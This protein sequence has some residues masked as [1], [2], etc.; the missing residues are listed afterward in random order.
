[1]QKESKMVEL[2]PMGSFEDAFLKA[3]KES[4][5]DS[6]ESVQE[7]ELSASDQEYD[8]FQGDF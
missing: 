7:R 4:K 6:Y 1:M 2:P 5:S 8:D 3:F